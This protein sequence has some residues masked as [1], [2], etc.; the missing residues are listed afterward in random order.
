MILLPVPAFEVVVEKRRGRSISML[1]AA[2]AAVSTG[3]V[4]SLAAV[5]IPIVVMERE[6]RRYRELR[7]G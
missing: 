5:V 1:R 4:A 6:G 7:G 2:L 3:I